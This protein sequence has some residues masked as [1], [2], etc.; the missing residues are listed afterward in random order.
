MRD[1]TALLLWASR[2]LQVGQQSAEWISCSS[3]RL[4]RTPCRT[5]RRLAAPEEDEDDDEGELESSLASAF[6]GDGAATLGAGNQPFM[7]QAVNQIGPFVLGKNSS[8][9][10][11]SLLRWGFL[12][13]KT[14]T[15]QYSTYVISGYKTLM[16]DIE[17]TI[18]YL[19]ISKWW[20]SIVWLV[21]STPLKN[22]SQIGSFPQVGVK[23][24][25]VWNHHLVVNVFARWCFWLSLLM[26]QL[27]GVKDLFFVSHDT[28][29][30]S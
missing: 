7:V 16:V 1:W 8:L 11:H 20:I 30:S 14:A 6:A 12:G 4:F 18:I 28:T 24:K 3:S 19:S 10:S 23:I 25:N 27:V 13:H 22:I 17:I 9:L 5:R 15:I 2:L 29:L 26:M 21:V